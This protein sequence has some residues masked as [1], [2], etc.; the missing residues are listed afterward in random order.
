MYIEPHSKEPQPRLKKEMA[1]K[2]PEGS[3]RTA[4]AAL[5]TGANYAPPQMAVSSKPFVGLSIEC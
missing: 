4:E 5:P 2:E 1:G 3:L